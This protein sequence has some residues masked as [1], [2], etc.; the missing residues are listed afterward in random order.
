MKQKHV[1]V[2]ILSIVLPAFAFGCISEAASTLSPGNNNTPAPSQN[3]SSG[4][5][6]ALIQIATLPKTTIANTANI[7]SAPQVSKHSVTINAVFP[8]MQAGDRNY[9]DFGTY[10]LSSPLVDGINPPLVWSAID[11]GPNAPGGQY[12]FETFDH[13]I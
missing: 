9:Q 5:G 12:Q 1:L 10:I 8:P 7:P 6:T 11:K 4:F 2:L 3:D 13:E